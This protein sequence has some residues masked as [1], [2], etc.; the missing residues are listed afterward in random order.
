MSDLTKEQLDKIQGKCWGDDQAY[1]GLP[2]RVVRQLVDMARQTLVA[3]ATLKEVEAEAAARRE[4]LILIAAGRPPALSQPGE[5]YC[6]GIAKKA[7]SGETGQALLEGVKLLP[8]DRRP[9]GT[10][11]TNTNGATPSVRE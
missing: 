8:E 5:L 10:V 6:I 1:Q 9:G 7:L 3:K 4:A 11:M 2:V